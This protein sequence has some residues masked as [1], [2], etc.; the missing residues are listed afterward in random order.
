MYETEKHDPHFILSNERGTILYPKKYLRKTTTATDLAIEARDKKEQTW[1]EI[2]PKA[3]HTYGK[4]FDKIKA[5]RFPK[6][7]PMGSHNRIHRRHSKDHRLQAHTIG[8]T[9]TG[10]V[11]QIPRRTSKEEVYYDL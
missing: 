1:Q 7:R 4:V 2:V 10:S 11:R 6:S 9:R 3:Y 8:T 5:M